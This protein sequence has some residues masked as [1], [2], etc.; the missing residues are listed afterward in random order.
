M[1]S[2]KD[3]VV[4]VLPIRNDDGGYITKTYAELLEEISTEEIEN[5]YNYLESLSSN[6]LSKQ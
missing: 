2:N 4:S 6:N 5:L 1:L 3:E